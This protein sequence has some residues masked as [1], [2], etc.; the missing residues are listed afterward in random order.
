M[1]YMIR[2][3][4]NGDNPPI[5]AIDS[6]VGV[7]STMERAEAVGDKILSSLNKEGDRYHA[8]MTIWNVD[9]DINMSFHEFV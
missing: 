3:E 4:P 6:T 2:I 5:C 1:V 9:E 7:F 8:I